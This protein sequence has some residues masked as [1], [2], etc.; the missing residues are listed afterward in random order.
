M[1]LIS[2]FLSVVERI[3]DPIGLRYVDYSFYQVLPLYS[4]IVLSKL[5]RSSIL[6]GLPTSVAR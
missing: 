5:T 4:K 2:F 6:R 1:F 3:D